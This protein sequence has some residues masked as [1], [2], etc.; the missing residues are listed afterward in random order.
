MAD[1]V[2]YH[3][4]LF[5]SVITTVPTLYVSFLLKS[6]HGDDTT[7]VL[8]PQTTNDNHP[9]IRSIL[10][11][12]FNQSLSAFGTK[13]MTSN[14]NALG[15]EEAAFLELQRRAEIERAQRLSDQDGHL[16]GA[17]LNLVGHDNQTG[18]EKA[19]V[20][21]NECNDAASTDS[22]LQSI[23]IRP[24]RSPIRPCSTYLSAN[25]LMRAQLVNGIEMSSA[26]SGHP[27][28][29]TLRFTTE[30]SE[31]EV[32][33]V[34]SCGIKHYFSSSLLPRPPRDQ[35]P[36]PPARK[37][38]RASRSKAP[39][40][41]TTSAPLPYLET[42]L[43]SETSTVDWGMPEHRGV[44][45]PWTTSQQQERARRQVREQAR[46]E[47]GVMVTVTNQHSQS[48]RCAIFCCLHRVEVEVEVAIALTMAMTWTS[49]WRPPTT[50]RVAVGAVGAQ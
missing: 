1:F 42:L 28:Q 34:R 37:A 22:S 5:S 44:V 10:Q 12:I 47:S 8:V 35:S 41:A 7:N 40:P 26:Q 48:G 49:I 21:G 23:V 19:K 39:S 50:S 33:N 4:R 13:R 14:R 2:V 3:M 20:S 32:N 31:G 45:N 15:K 30:A 6:Y 16:T 17:S 46:D 29:S 9:Q 27:M 36:P 25:S 43:L 18:A 38:Q 11:S 24:K